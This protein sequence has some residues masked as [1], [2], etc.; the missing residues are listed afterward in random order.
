[1]SPSRRR[2]LRPASLPSQSNIRTRISLGTT[3]A[4]NEPGIRVQRVMLTTGANSPSGSTR[5]AQ[6]HTSGNA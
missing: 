4:I 1:M 3:A 6:R 2:A 5:S